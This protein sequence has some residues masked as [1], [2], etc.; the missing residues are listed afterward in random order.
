M[1][2]TKKEYPAI[3]DLTRFTLF[4]PIEGVQ[5]N[6]R[7]AYARLNWSMREGYPRIS[8]FGINSK[9][10]E[11]EFVNIS[12]DP[13]NFN[14]FLIDFIE[15]L[16]KP[17][18]D[19]HMIV[20]KSPVKDKN[21]KY[22]SERV[23]GATLWYGVKK[24]GVAFIALE[25]PLNNTNRYIFTFEGRPYLIFKTKDGDVI[26]QSELSR[27]YAQSTCIGLQKIFN[28]QF[29]EFE[30]YAASSN[31]EPGSE[32]VSNQDVAVYQF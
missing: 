23:D 10:K 15:L 12:M 30:E 29:N 24:D 25:N 32:K 5:Q 22:T 4:A 26:P 8:V 1:N 31:K 3:R 19:V 13:I 20:N 28:M 21:G 27:L 6:G 7:Q 17:E 11:K 18:P 16:K 14:A 2:E 9:T